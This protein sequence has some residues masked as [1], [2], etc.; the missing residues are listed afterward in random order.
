MAEYMT[1]QKRTLKR[2]LEENSD[3]AYT[4]EELF[5]KMAVACP[6]K[7]PGKSTVYRLITHLV[8]DGTVKRFARSGGRKFAYQIV[9]GEHCD[10]HLHLKCMECGKLLHLNDKVSDELLLKVRD[11]V[12][13][14]VSEEATVLFGKCGAC[15]RATL[16]GAKK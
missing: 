16:G 12:D 9:A 10:C 4:V 11:T 14:S 8:N 5:E 2:I 6:D 13:F 1:E 7:A 15:K 3:R